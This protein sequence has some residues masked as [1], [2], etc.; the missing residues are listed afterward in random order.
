MSFL[1]IPVRPGAR[2]EA[3]ISAVSPPHALRAPQIDGDQQRAIDLLVAGG[4]VPPL[5]RVPAQVETPV[6]V[7]RAS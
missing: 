3:P 6:P 4:L 2:A 1:T 5:R 7:H